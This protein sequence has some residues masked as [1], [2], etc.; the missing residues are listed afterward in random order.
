MLFCCAFVSTWY[1]VLLYLCVRSVPASLSSCST[2]P[3]SNRWRK[4][5]STPSQEKLATHWAKTNSSGSRLTT[6][7]WW[8]HINRAPLLNGE[9]HLQQKKKKNHINFYDTNPHLYFFTTLV[10]DSFDWFLYNNIIDHFF[11]CLLRRWCASLRRARQGRRFRWR[12]WTVTQWPRSKT[13]CWTLF[14]KE[15]RFRS[16]PRPMTWTWVTVAYELSDL[17]AS[18]K[19]YNIRVTLT[20]SAFLSFLCCQSGV[21]GVWP[22]SFCRMK[23]WP[24][25]SRVTGRDSTH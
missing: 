1:C 4:D 11:F 17:S 10:W 23:T 14:T 19:T 2:A 21:R 6:N 5:P 20:G 16:A 7:S 9:V 18:K 15:S 25:R 22:A 12:C 13:N 8:T 24:R 3:S